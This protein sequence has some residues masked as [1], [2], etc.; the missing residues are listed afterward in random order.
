MRIL[1]YTYSDSST[2]CEEHAL[3]RGLEDEDNET[4][5]AERIF[6]TDEAHYDIVCDVHGCGII[7]AQNVEDE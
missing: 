7:Q 3:E 5:E 2:L 4:G 1:G 6:S